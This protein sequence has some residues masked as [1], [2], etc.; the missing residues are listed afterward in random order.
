[1]MNIFIDQRI[2]DNETNG[3]RLR[4]AIHKA[5]VEQARLEGSA[6]Q[7]AIVAESEYLRGYNQCAADMLGLMTS[8]LKGDR[9]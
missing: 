5:Q 8:F 2:L 6:E 4:S 9:S 7:R 1:M 3:D